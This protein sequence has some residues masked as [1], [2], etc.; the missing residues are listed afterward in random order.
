MNC[1]SGVYQVPQG[2]TVAIERFGK[3]ERFLKPG[4]NFVNPFMYM[5]KDL[6]EWRG[7]ASKCNYLM[8]LTEQQME[9]S[10][11]SCQTKDNVTV[12][13][14][15]VIY[16]II[17][18]PEKAV[19]KIDVLPKSLQDMCLNVLRS[20]VG[21]YGFDELFSKRA[22]LSKK[23]TD[24]LKEKVN[25]WGID[26][27]GV[28]IGK[29]SYDSGL[30]AA[31][32]KKRIAEAEKDAQVTK[33]ESV[34]LTAIKEAETNFKRSEIE[35]KS[36]QN[37][38]R[39]EAEVLEIQATGKAKAIEI[40]AQGNNKVKEFEN[41]HID[42]LVQ[43]V[44]RDGAIHLLSTSKAVEGLERLANNSSHKLVFLPNDFK[45]MIKLVNAGSLQK[46]EDS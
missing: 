44:G 30:Y 40:E 46:G 14:N 18:D 33:A 37:Q 21:S 15:A 7:I 42:D 9:T 26:L 2:H 16:F 27:I 23:I 41:K 34:A 31:L 1:I 12:E 6:S 36:K 35:F 10:V 11:R 17:S 32:Q 43:K 45:G 25:S 3:F 13:S 20:K 4:L 38:A 22:E 28:E 19:Y 39:S 5:H 24:E 29:I 8:E